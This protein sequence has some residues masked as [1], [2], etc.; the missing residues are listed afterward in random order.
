ML[1]NVNEHF[2]DEFHCFRIPLNLVS[3]FVPMVKR[4]IVR[5]AFFRI[6]FSGGELIAYAFHRIFIW[7][8]GSDLT[9]SVKPIFYVVLVSS[10]VV[11][12]G[13]AHSGFA[14]ANADGRPV[15]L[16]IFHALKEFLGGEFRKI[17]DEP[18]PNQT[19]SRTVNK[20]SCFVPKDKKNVTEKFSHKIHC[21]IRKPAYYNDYSTNCTI[22]Q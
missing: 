18:L 17:V 11:K 21:S 14:S 22:C 4:H 2:L 8:Q 1:R 5:V 20:Y 15:S 19:A 9:V 13:T 6:S 10:L 3:V 12:P 7:H 16:I